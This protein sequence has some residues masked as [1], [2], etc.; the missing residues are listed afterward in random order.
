MEDA[1]FT[2][3]G[4]PIDTVMFMQFLQARKKGFGKIVYDIECLIDDDSL[5][6][7][8]SAVIGPF[9][10]PERQRPA[11]RT[12]NY[13]GLQSHKFNV[14]AEK[15]KKD[16]RKKEYYEREARLKALCDEREKEQ[17][18]I[19]DEKK[20]LHEKEMKEEKRIKAEKRQERIKEI[21]ILITSLQDQHDGLI[22]SLKEN[23]DRQQ[24]LGNNYSIWV[25]RYKE[26]QSEHA[27]LLEQSDDDIVTDEMKDLVQEA[28]TIRERLEMIAKKHSEI[29]STTIDMRREVREKLLHID[30]L[31][32]EFGESGW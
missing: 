25:T 17:K 18:R 9:Y 8:S 22:K 21:V 14:M 3:N 32:K 29:S 12:R 31:K 13:V 2:R 16:V 23:D 6:F 30:L 26:I 5:E 19:E 1:P 10:F 11:L 20:T 7:L 4:M 28:I 15:N 24:K 27:N